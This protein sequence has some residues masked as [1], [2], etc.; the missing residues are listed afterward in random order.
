M[1]ACINVAQSSDYKPVWLNQDPL[2]FGEDRAQ[3][4]TDYA[5]VIGK[6]ALAQAANS[7]AGDAKAAAETGARISAQFPAA[8]DDQ[9][10]G[11]AW[12]LSRAGRVTVP[13][14]LPLMVDKDARCWVTYILGMQNRNA[15]LTQIEELRR[16]DPE[17]YFAV[18]VLWKILASWVYDL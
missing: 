1:G 4:G 16:C 13:E 3:L 12:A 9:R 8:Q 11:I 17:V 10:A 5:A 2:A 6:A 14:L 15:F 18:T 7:G